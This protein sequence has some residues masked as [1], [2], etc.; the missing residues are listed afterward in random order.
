MYRRISPTDYLQLHRFPSYNFVLRYWVGGQSGSEYNQA[1][2]EEP[3]LPLTVHPRVLKKRPWLSEKGIEWAWNTAVAERWRIE[4]SPLQIAKVGFD[5]T[6]HCLEMV[7]FIDAEVI[8][9]YHATVATKKF[10]QEVGLTSHEIRHL[11]KGEI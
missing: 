11:T 7:A 1:E 9:I 5:P 2:H 4:A 3:V 6:G 10:L 8:T